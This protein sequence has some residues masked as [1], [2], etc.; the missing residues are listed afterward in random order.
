[1]AQDQVSN[2]V[3]HQAD[4]CLHGNQQPAVGFRHQALGQWGGQAEADAQHL[5]TDV[6][7]SVGVVAGVALAHLT[8]W[9]RLDPII[10]LVV[11]VGIVWTGVSLVRRSLLGL[12]DTGLPEALRDHIVAILNARRADGVDYHALRTRQAATRRFVSVHILV[13]GD[14][15]V[16]RGHDLLERIEEEIR[17][18]IPRCTVFTH[19]E[20][21]EDPVSWADTRLERLSGGPHSPGPGS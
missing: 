11:A 3:G 9:Y 12:L 15:S 10:A 1:M 19:L 18:A 6:W 20:P 4:D 5:M 7:T 14:W 13:P 8:G 17:E 2:Q 16:Q 21:L